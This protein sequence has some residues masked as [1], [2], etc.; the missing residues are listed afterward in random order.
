MVDLSHIVNFSLSCFLVVKR[1]ITIVEGP[2]IGCLPW[3]VFK[4]SQVIKIPLEEKGYQK[5]FYVYKLQ[6]YHWH[7]FLFCW[8]FHRILG[9]KTWEDLWSRHQADPHF[10]VRKS[11]FRLYNLPKITKLVDVGVKL[12]WSLSDSKACVSCFTFF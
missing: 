5:I 10:S 9:N 7:L 4:L 1:K 2:D 3:K 12:E 11:R 6:N 8:Y